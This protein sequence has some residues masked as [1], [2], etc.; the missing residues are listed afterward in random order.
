MAAIGRGAI[1]KVAMATAMGGQNAPCASY[2][3]PG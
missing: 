2:T 3:V 1:G